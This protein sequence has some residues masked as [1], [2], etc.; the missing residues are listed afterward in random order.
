MISIH[1]IPR[2][3]AVA[4]FKQRRGISKHRPTHPNGIMPTGIVKL[5]N[6]Q[7]IKLE[8]DQSRKK[9]G[10]PPPKT[11]FFTRRSLGEGGKPKPG[12][13]TFLRATNN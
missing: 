6:C 13:A 7:F 11:P 2:S 8:Q 12:K 5:S 3:P 9:I 4:S 10:S 1:I